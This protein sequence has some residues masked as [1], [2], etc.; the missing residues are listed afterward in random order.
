ML[1]AGGGYGKI[2]C[3]ESEHTPQPL[4]KRRK[5]GFYSTARLRV[6]M[7]ENVKA[8]RKE[9]NADVAKTSVRAPLPKHE[10]QKIDR[11]PKSTVVVNAPLLPEKVAS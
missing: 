4:E 2:K 3:L 6:K 8:A 10:L 1:L 9:E 7:N 5:E 11:L